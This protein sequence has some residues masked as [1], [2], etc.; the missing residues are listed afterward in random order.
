MDSR[1]IILGRCLC[2][3]QLAL[4]QMI[5]RYTA[6]CTNCNAEFHFH[7]DM[8]P[9]LTIDEWECY[10]TEKVDFIADEKVLPF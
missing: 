2:G 5:D 7:I 3:H 4:D 8:E 6:K 10:E 9:M 1:F